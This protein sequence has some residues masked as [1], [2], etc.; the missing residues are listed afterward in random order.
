MKLSDLPKGKRAIGC[1]W[2]FTKKQ[3][4]SD[5]DTVCYKAKLVAKGYAQ[6]KGIDY[7]VFS[8]SVKHLSIR[9]LLAQVT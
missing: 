9:I 1:K 4:S 5:G 3:G 7:E 6:R 8:P 2:V